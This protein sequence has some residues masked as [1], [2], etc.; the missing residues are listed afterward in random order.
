MRS[1]IPLEGYDRAAARA[2]AERAEYFRD[3]LRRLLGRR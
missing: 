2:R 3:V 1:P